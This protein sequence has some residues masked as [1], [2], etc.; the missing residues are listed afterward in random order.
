RA[1]RWRPPEA[2]TSPGRSASIRST[3]VTPARQAMPTLPSWRRTTPAPPR[4]ERIGDREL[5]VQFA[6]ALAG[7]RPV[8]ALRQG[9]HEGNETGS[10]VA[11]DAASDEIDDFVLARRRAG[12]CDTDG[13]DGLAPLR[14]GDADH[15]RV[16]QLRMLAQ[17]GLD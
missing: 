10:L 1:A 4:L 12:G 8:R 11:G 17:H 2:P 9:C 13:L 6:D 3:R 7:V 15:G 5:S 16:D 14:I